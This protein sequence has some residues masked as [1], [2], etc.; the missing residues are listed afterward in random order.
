MIVQIVRFRSSQ[1]DEEV[2][3]TYEARAPQYRALKD[4]IQKYYLHYPDTGEH[5][6]V[7]VWRSE[8][9]MKAFRESEL[10]RTIASAYQ[11]Q[12]TPDFTTAEIEMLLRP[13][14]A[15]QVG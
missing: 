2:R 12:G 10:G 3:R 7:Y 5:G 13:E 8:A 1:S 6:A 9:A 11:V 14:Q 15:E 4:L